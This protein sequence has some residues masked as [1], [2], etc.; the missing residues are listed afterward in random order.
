[1]SENPADATGSTPISVRPI[2]VIGGTGPAGMG[3]AFRWARAGETII[4]GSRD[5]ERA[6]KAAASIKLRAPQGN[7]SGM[8]NAAA[9]AAA[10]IL[11][12][13]VPF[14]GQAKLLKQLKNSMTPGSILIDATV[15][16]AAGVG[17]RA[18]RTLGV[19]Q[20]SAA[21]QAA[22]LVPEE[23]SVVAAF[24]NVSAD[25][26]GGEHPLDCDVIVCSDDPDAGQLTR[27]LAAKIPGV[28]AIDGG[29]LE[30]ARIIEQITAL[31]IGL[32][33][34]HKGHGGIRITGL[35]AE[36]YK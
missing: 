10:D 34:R 28:R 27:E 2:A 19:W 17:G 15:P 8:E 35:P 14:E 22:E 16:L 6:K 20:G 23:V 36:A 7:V 12:L 3:L 25:L 11:M 1:M 32:N 21:Q 24:H 30:N 4:I 18:S 5:A 13:T 33:I 29:T 31:L 9:C 26:L